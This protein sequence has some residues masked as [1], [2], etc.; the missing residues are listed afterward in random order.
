MIVWM[1]GII[2][3]FLAGIGPGG[4]LALA[5][6][7]AFLT[8]DVIR[9]RRNLVVKNL[10]RVYGPNADPNVCALVGRASVVNFI[11]TTLEFFSAHRVFPSYK[12][13]FKNPEKM[14]EALERGRGV[15]LMG[16]HMGNFELLGTAIG[17][18]FARIHAPVKPIG[19]G[20]LAQWVKKR[21]EENGIVE[22]VNQ[23]GQ[24]SSRTARIMEGLRNNEVVGFMVDQRRS[25]GLLLP[26]F[27]E[28][29]WT[30]TGLIYLWK[31]HQAPILPVTITRRGQ[32]TAEITFHDEFLIQNES[33][34]TFEQ[35]VLEN[36]KKMNSIVE[37]LIVAN[38]KEYFWMHDRWKK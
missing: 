27:G 29:A 4:R 25:K 10:V 20:R 30:N 35:F 21:R 3:L 34:W 26:F 16:I 13:E 37:Q 17:K 2:G 24:G 19:K 38:P 8:F 15:Y 18:N 14:R 22:I 28:P 32:T 1:A 12:I 6:V 23:R 11:L 36:T 31:Q 9:V 7:L 5:R 33:G